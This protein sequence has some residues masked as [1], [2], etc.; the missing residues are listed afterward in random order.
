MWRRLIG[1]GEGRYGKEERDRGE[2][3]YG[4]EEGKPGEK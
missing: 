1:K 3:R 4:K 2:K